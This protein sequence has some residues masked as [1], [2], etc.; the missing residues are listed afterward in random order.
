MTKKLP[1]RQS[2]CYFYKFRL[3]KMCFISCQLKRNELD[4]FAFL[5]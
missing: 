5:L 2:Y 3:S 1:L 4:T